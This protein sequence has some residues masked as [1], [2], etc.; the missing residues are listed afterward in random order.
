MMAGV[1]SSQASFDFSHNPHAGAL[2]QGL[3]ELRSDN[4]LVDVSLC[5]SG[6]EIP[7]HRNV[8]AAC[9]E[10][11]RAMFCNG[12]R[13]SKERTITIHE[14]NSNVMQLLVDYSYTSKVTITENNAVEL[15]EGANFLQIQPVHDACVTYICNNLGAKDCLQMMQ[16]G[17][18]L[19]C[20][21]LE[22]KAR[23]C[24][25]KE[26]AA[27]SKT[28]AFL[29]LTKDQLTTLVSSD[30]LIAT[31]EVVYEAVM[32]WINHDTR[33]RRKEMRELM[34]LVRFPFMDKMYFLENVE[35]DDAVRK[36]CLDIVKETHKFYLFPGEVQ[37]PRTR[38]RPAS[39]W[40][41]E[42]VTIGGI[43]KQQTGG[44]N[45][46]EYD[47]CISSGYRL[48]SFLPRKYQNDSVK[49][50]VF[51]AATLGTSDIIFSS[52][53]DVFLY[54]R[55]LVSWGHGLT[56]LSNMNTERH[57]H[58]L[59]VSHGKVY[60]IGG[61]NDDMPALTSVEVYDRRENYW[62]EG[63]ALPQARY[64]HAVAVLDGNI[65]VMGGYDAEKK[66][67]S[68][69]YRFKPG[70]SEWQPQK[71][72]P[73]RGACITAVALNGNI[74]VAGLRS[75]VL[76][77]K[78]GECGG[79]WSIAANTGVGRFCG[80]AVFAGTIRI[81][82]G[83]NKGKGSRDIWCLD[84]ETRSLNHVGYMNKGLFSQACVTTL[85]YRS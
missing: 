39:G 52:G 51:A 56:A 19:S 18:M 34:E 4:Q 58:K 8:L 62:K 21:D 3:L 53:R 16:V 17:N 83:Y 82:G 69:V 66:L 49:A 46:T 12:H 20:P 30:D 45:R 23:M 13:E 32:T 41:E 43:R 27:V 7:C 74:Y 80:M 54:L 47:R 14:V 11:F 73:V 77:F 26:F 44:N 81:Y 22:D 61:R 63:V 36:S 42:V 64:N 55:E 79:A 38:P 5:V 31:E 50:P 28:P 40:R 72:M 84:P 85:N 2:L 37:S 15:L 9:S 24:A 75:K 25:L 68:T 59:A 60:A 29:S 65:Y 1:Q 48:L 33:K 78:P 71:D 10:Y 67:T 76:C 6:L 35:N 70:D 57:D